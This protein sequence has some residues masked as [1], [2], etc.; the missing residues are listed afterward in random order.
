ML[1]YAKVA[2]VKYLLLRI[3]TKT[4]PGAGDG[5]F[6][7]CFANLSDNLLLPNYLNYF[8][9][10]MLIVLKSLIQVGFPVQIKSTE[11]LN[12]FQRMHPWHL[13]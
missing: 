10:E 8:L 7:C 2:C 13:N 1:R 9:E 4:T 5:F 11:C 6:D 3:V 12:Y